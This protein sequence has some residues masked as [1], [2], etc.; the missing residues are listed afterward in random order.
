MNDEAIIVEIHQIQD[1]L[2]TSLSSLVW[3]LRMLTHVRGRGSKDCA[4]AAAATATQRSYEETAMFVRPPVGA[5]RG[6]RPSQL[7]RLL[8]KMTG[9][10]WRMTSRSFW[11]MRFKRLKMQEGHAV[12]LIG[13]RRW[14]LHCH[15][16]TTESNLVYDPDHPE[17]VLASAYSK[18]GWFVA[19]ILTP[20]K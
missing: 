13:R 15:T 18:S 1:V 10:S 8:E 17:P 14:S 4:I 20:P 6:L 2:L 12:V 7:K 5:E 9:R 16:I 3:G 19:Y 11:P